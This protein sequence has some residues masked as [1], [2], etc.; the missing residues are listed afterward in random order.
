MLLEFEPPSCCACLHAWLRRLES[1]H[2]DRDGANSD[3][4]MGKSN[5]LSLT[6][7]STFASKCQ[8]GH[9]KKVYFRLAQHH[10]WGV[11]RV[12]TRHKH[13]AQMQELELFLSAWSE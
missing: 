2:K 1:Y 7:Y 5:A 6:H 9:P 11:T 12:A 3:E 13:V 10:D 4:W 8:R